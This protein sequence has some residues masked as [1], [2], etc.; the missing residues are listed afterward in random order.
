MNGLFDYSTWAHSLAVAPWW[1]TALC[2]ITVVLTLA[3]AFHL[4]LR[5]HHPRWRVILWRST[6][7]G[8]LVVARLDALHLASLSV[9]VAP[10]ERIETVDRVSVG[11]N[12]LPTLAPA[13]ASE[14]LN[15]ASSQPRVS[16]SKFAPAPTPPFTTSEIAQVVT[17]PPAQHSFAWMAATMLTIWIGG[18]VCLMLRWVLSKW[19]LRSIVADSRPVADWIERECHRICDDMGIRSCRIIESEFPGSPCLGW[20]ARGPVLLI[21]SGIAGSAAPDEMTAILTHELSH[22]NSHDLPWNWCVNAV[23]GLLWPHPLCWAVGS[24]HRRACEDAADA[25]SVRRLGETEL[26]S[27]TL[28]KVAL[29]VAGQQ[30]PVG[31]AMARVSDVRRRLDRVKKSFELLPLS[32]RQIV[33][34]IGLAATVFLLLGTLRIVDAAPPA[35]E[36]QTMQADAD[37]QRSIIVSVGDS[38][39]KPIDGATLQVLCFAEKNTMDSLIPKSLGDDKYKITLPAATRALLLE[40][41]APHHVPSMATWRDDELDTDLG[42]T[43]EFRMVKGTEISGRVVDEQGDPIEGATVFVLDSTGTQDRVR[44]QEA[45]RDYPVKTG[46]DGRWVC[47]V[48]PK[49]ASEILLE[50]THPDYISDSN[51]GETASRVPVNQLRS[52]THQM[53]MKKGVAV[54]GRV[55]DSE[56][57]PVVGAMVYQGSDRPGS[58]F[59]ATKTDA[60][61]EFTFEHS[62]LGT[63]VLT[64]VAKGLAPDLKVIQVTPEM[65]EVKFRLEPGKTLRLRAVGPDGEPLSGVYVGA[66]TWRGHRSLTDAEIPRETND[67]GVYIWDNAPSDEVEFALLATGF[68]D[69]RQYKLTAREEEYTVRFI[70]PLTVTGSVVNAKTK[71]PVEVFE[72]IQGIKLEQGDTIHWERNRSKLGNAGTYQSRFDYPYLGHLVRIEAPGYEPVV[73]RVFQSDEGTV[74]LDFELNPVPAVKGIVKTAD[75][76]PV[77]GAQVVLATADRRV[78]VENGRLTD[79]DRQT[80]AIS[81]ADGKFELP[82]SAEAFN[83]L[84][85]NE[86]GAT[87]IASDEFRTGQ[88]VEL[89]PWASVSGTVMIGS[90]AAAQTSVSLSVLDPTPIDPIMFQISDRTE[91]DDHGHFSFSRVLPDSECLVVRDISI[92][93]RYPIPTHRQWFTTKPGQNIEVNIGGTGRL[94]V[95]HATIP[96]TIAKYHWGICVIMPDLENYQFPEGVDE[97]S[98]EERQVWFDKWSRT[99]EGVAYN[100][101]SWQS[102]AVVV[103]DDGRFRIEDIPS[104]DYTLSLSINTG[105]TPNPYGTSKTLDTL[106][107]KFTVPEMA[108]GRSD[109][110][111]DLGD[112]TLALRKFANVGDTAPNFQA[113]TLSGE[114]LQLSDYA[115]KYVLLDFWA[116]WCEPCIAEIPNLEKAYQQFPDDSRFVIISLNIDNDVDTVATYLQEHPMPWLQ[117]HLGT[118]SDAQ[119]DYGIQSIPATFL[120]GPDGNVIAKDLRG[121]DLVKKIAEVLH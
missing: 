14:T 44:P 36:P 50:L 105:E 15:T 34:S 31:L 17:K 10:P 2:K 66:D 7:A 56:R 98:R 53:V 60:S 115:G 1:L 9:A 4:M 86:F 13:P 89:L 27:R 111:L 59:P 87:T 67:D 110:P 19:R 64:V 20:I 75:G 81:D 94:V 109:Q 84:F 79:V 68:L 30:R 45:V 106:R 5:T 22:L 49:E 48:L 57:K 32:R 102:F 16:M 83:L 96:K 118:D 72:V 73:S 93:P 12:T 35:E 51:Y 24:A 62:K 117:G 70:R 40:A 99:E 82:S 113:T 18:M 91:T 112:L 107:H 41:K 37:A 33:A 114:S 90:R 92:D 38:D 55:V 78:V 103:G 58:D 63:M 74:T 108:G 77:A 119:S 3:W 46:V 69:K 6:I 8:V 104:G 26:Y 116:T 42:D 101:K 71:E 28:A 80:V 120:I 21:P 61:G 23:T 47:D 97:M 95:G 100:K 39:G 85:L 54:T 121:E 52:G 11:N 29:S 25:E 76:Q 65:D 88:T 43:F